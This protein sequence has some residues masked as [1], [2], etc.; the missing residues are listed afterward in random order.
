[1]CIL[2]YEFAADDHWSDWAS[3]TE[4]NEP[5]GRA[6]FRRVHI[7]SQVLAPCGLTVYDP[8]S[9][10]HLVIADHKGAAEVAAGLPAVWQA[11]ARLSPRQVDVLDP[12]L[13]EKLRA[14]GQA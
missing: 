6:R 7:L 12:A 5:P 1:M 13:L 4:L 9:G 11:A 3:D 10:P 14:G 8:G 2:C